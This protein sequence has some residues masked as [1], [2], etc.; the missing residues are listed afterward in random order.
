MEL[1][2]WMESKQEEAV[3][4]SFRFSKFECRFYEQNGTQLP[5]EVEPMRAWSSQFPSP[6]GDST[7]AS[8]FSQSWISI[9]STNTRD[10]HKINF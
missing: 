7:V 1:G 5:S 2:E 9:L 8:L 4:Q 10:K 6:T 3:R